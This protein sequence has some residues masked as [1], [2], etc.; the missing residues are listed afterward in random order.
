MLFFSKLSIS[1]DQTVFFEKIFKKTEFLFGVEEGA[2]FA[3]PLFTVR[4]ELKSPS[5]KGN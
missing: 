2:N 3:C 5:K 4:I 1:G